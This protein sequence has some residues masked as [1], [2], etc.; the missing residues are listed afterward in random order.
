MSTLSGLGISLGV[1][2]QG[3]LSKNSYPAVLKSREV[4]LSVVRDTFRI[5]STDTTA[6]LVE[7]FGEKEASLC[8]IFTPTILGGQRA[9]GRNFKMEEEQAIQRVQDMVMAYQNPQTGLMRISVTAGDPQL[10]SQ[11]ANSLVEHL[12]A[13]VRHIRT[14]K[15]REKSE[16]I[17]QQFEKANEKLSAAEERL[18]DFLE[19]N[20]NIQSAELQTKRDRLEREVRFE[21]SLYSELQGQLTQAELELKRREPVL[22][23]VE[24]PIP[25]R[26]PIAP[27]WPRLIVMI[28]MT[29][30]AF[31]GG[32]GSISS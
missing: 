10:A 3:G 21:T 24:E 30:T 4:R 16:F 5:P 26:E 32:T 9:S 17:S 6:T 31:D 27:Q 22:T 13:R 7:Y 15:A 11:V 8:H 14:R 12:T 25:P 1:A 29:G 19:R 23:T 2:S 20:K 18:A 28:L